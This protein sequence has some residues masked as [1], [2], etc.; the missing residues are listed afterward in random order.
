[1]DTPAPLKTDDCFA[2]ATDDIMRFTSKGPLLSH[3]RMS[4]IDKA[5]ADHGIERKAEKDVPAATNGT[6]SGIDLVDGTYFCTCHH[7]VG[8]SAIWRHLHL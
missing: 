8:S 6:A 4:D 5:L 7:K 2:L 1:M 3:R